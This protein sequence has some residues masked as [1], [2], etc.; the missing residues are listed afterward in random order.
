MKGLLDYMSPS[1]RNLI[2]IFLASLG[3]GAEAREECVKLKQLPPGEPIF[4]CSGYPCPPWYPQSA[5]HYRLEGKVILLLKVNS[6]GAATSVAVAVPSQHSALNKAAVRA[7]KKAV[8]PI[9]RPAG[10]SSPQCYRTHYPIEF[11]LR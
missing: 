2:I 4:Q 5:M 3:V 9:Y 6:A 8:F 1:I 10:S 7:A 11:S